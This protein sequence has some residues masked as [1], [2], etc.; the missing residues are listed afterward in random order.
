MLGRKAENLASKRSR[1]ADL[2]ETHFE[3]VARY[4]AIRIGNI[5]EAEDLA[6]E[7]FV[8]A[9]R[10]VDSYRETGA[11]MEAW[12]FKIAH[13]AVVDHLRKRS[14]RPGLVQVDEALP[15]VSNHDPTDNLERQ[16]EVEELHRA[17]SRLSKAQQQVLALRFGAEMTSEQAAQVMG[18]KPGAVREMQS[19]ALKKLREILGSKSA[20]LAP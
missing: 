6:S 13:N 9:L 15:V 19:A 7:V 11:P 5:S 3:R 20:Q 4:I 10:S 18:K 8:R 12:V 16:E 1:V 14:R 17:V 2:Y